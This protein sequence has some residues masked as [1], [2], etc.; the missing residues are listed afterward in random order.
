ME[1]NRDKWS[2]SKVIR[3][4]KSIW[5]NMKEYDQIQGYLDII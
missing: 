4:N 1:V 5:E 2:K 3:D